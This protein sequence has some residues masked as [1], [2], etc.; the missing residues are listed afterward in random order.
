MDRSVIERRMLLRGAG[1]AGAAAVGVA[2][3]P[4]AASAQEG[5]HGSRL[6]GA[7][8]ITHTDNPQGQNTPVVAIVTFAAGG[9]F[10]NLDI[11]PPSSLGLGAW[12]SSGDHFKATFWQGDAGNGA[13]APP[14]VVRVQVRGRVHDDR[15]SGTYRVT[16]FS[17]SD[18]S[19]LARLTGVFSGSRLQA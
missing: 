7:W 8:R 15:I 11:N 17:A 12:E 13:S 16:V 2:A 6:L 14:V 9:V 4:A 5:H 1:V 10:T 18:N 3:V 19:V